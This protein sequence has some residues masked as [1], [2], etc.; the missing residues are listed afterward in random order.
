MIA[1]PFPPPLHSCSH[2]LAVVSSQMTGS[3]AHYLDADDRML[4]VK[5]GAA[6]TSMFVVC[7]RMPGE[8]LLE[9]ISTVGQNVST[10]CI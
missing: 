7:V 3:P 4:S 8:S 6:P 10:S 5:A 9:V 1:N 2:R